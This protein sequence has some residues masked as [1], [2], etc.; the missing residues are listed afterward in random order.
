MK[1]YIR[2]SVCFP[3][4]LIKF[5]IIKIFHLKQF[6]FYPLELFS[7]NS[8]MSI[9]KNSK[10]ILGKYVRCQSNV[11][12]RA[13]KNAILNIGD[14]TAF[15]TGCV[16]TCRHNIDIGSGVI[17]GQN[18]LIYDHDHD[19]RAEGGIKAKKY[20]YG[21]VTIGDNCWIGANT[22]ILRGTTI[23][24]NCVVGAGSVINGNYPDNS[25]IVQKRETSIIDY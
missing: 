4:T 21:K 25:V 18:V 2:Y 8:E 12:I 19:F 1:K 15:N 23:G 16:I 24:N 22:V 9:G 5:C 7:V 14:N 3:Y 20:K 6:K 10:V 13:R 17:F 11:R